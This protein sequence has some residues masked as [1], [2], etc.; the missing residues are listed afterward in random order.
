MSKLDD[1]FND[2]NN[3][4]PYEGVDEEIVKRNIKELFLELVD[5]CEDYTVLE[6]GEEEQHFNVS[7]L[8]ESIKEL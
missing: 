2:D 5:N 4:I 3:R 7:K 6:N 1:I 8:S